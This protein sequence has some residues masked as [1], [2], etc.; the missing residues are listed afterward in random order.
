MGT[1]NRNRQEIEDALSELKSSISFRGGN[2]NV[3]A[4]ISST[5]EN[6]MPTLELM[7]DMLKN[8][9]FDAAEL[10]TLKTEALA[11]IEASKS[12][13]QAIALNRIS[14]LCHR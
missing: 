7:A 1:K 9:S 10:E 5:K 4:N 8:P 2:G 11:G 14:E 6:L 3:Y 12:E 13:P